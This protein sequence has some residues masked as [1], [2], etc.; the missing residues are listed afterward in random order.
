MRSNVNQTLVLTKLTTG[1][2]YKDGFLPIDIV[3]N[4][5]IYNGAHLTYFERALQSN[6]QHISLN[7]GQ[8]LSALGINITSI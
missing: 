4:S 1:P 3:G 2:K 7:V 8:A 6:T 5:S